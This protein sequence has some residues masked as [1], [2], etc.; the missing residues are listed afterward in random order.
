M[1]NKEDNIDSYKVSLINSR[2]AP[3]S[4]VHKCSFCFLSSMS[5][6]TLVI[7]LFTMIGSL[8]IFV[9][10]TLDITY[11]SEL[12]LMISGAA[13]I[14]MSILL[15]ISVCNYNN[16]FAKFILFTF[17]TF[18]FIIFAI[19]G[20][21][22]IYIALY[23]NSNG[24]VNVT[25]I[26]NF[27]N[28]SMHYTYEICCNNTNSTE[29]LRQVCYDVMGHNETIIL[30]ECSSFSIFENDFLSYIHNILKWVL[31]I[32]G[33][34]AIVNMISGITSCCLIAARKR[35]FYYKNPEVSM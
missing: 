29:V 14:M 2:D 28:E 23:F 24:L 1:N 11:G 19:C 5:F 7:G 16:A 6:I 26:D 34:V 17:S 9:T 18:A 15:L 12:F 30:K 32:G 35:I 3:I 25:E 31:S 4:S 13:T 10:N 33:I 8:Y 21:I 27:F 22:T 20:S